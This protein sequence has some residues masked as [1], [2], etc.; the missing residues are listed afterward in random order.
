[1]REESSFL[2]KRVVELEESLQNE[3]EERV[4][5]QS[6]F[7]Q[8]NEF[9]LCKMQAWMAEVGLKLQIQSPL[10]QESLPLAKNLITE[11][12]MQDKPEKKTLQS[13]VPP[14]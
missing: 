3:R 13:G 9:V 11:E 5:L 10:F 8:L 1:L 6:T 14:S 12:E 4:V 2:K 7:E